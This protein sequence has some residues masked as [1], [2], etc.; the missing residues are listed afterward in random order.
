M[1]F[2]EI[3]RVESQMI[4]IRNIEDVTSAIIRISELARR[5]GF[6]VIEKSSVMTAVSELAHNILKYANHGRLTMAIVESRIGRGI[7]IVAEDHGPGIAD[8]QMAMRDHYSESG[9]LG[10]GLPGSKRLMDEFALW[11][12]PGAGTRVTARKWKS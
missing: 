6:N 11:S 8:I 9:T 3:L 12:E 10:L 7:E 1:M 4:A 5:I 2:N